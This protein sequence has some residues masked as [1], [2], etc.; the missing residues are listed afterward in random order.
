MSLINPL[1]ERLTSE[2]AKSLLS[3]SLLDITDIVVFGASIMEQSFS[4]TSD[5]ESKWLDSGAIVDVHERAT[6]GDDT[7]QMITRLPAII[8]EFQANADKTL[9]VIHWGG[10]DVSRDGPYPG[11]AATMEANMRSMLDDI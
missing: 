1:V 3:G 2:L 7:A 8:T 9:F 10:N 4:D 11:G 5:T 6:S